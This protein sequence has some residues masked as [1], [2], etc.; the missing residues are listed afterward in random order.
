MAWQREWIKVPEHYGPEDRERL[1]YLYI[2]HIIE[3][4]QND[5]DR[6]NQAFKAYK[7]P[8]KGKYSKDYAESLDFKNAGKSSGKIDL[9][10]TGD[11][12]AELTLLR[13]QRGKVLIGYEKGS[14]A[15][16]KVE[17][18]RLGN[19]KNRPPRDFLGFKTSS[20]LGES[21]RERKRIVRFYE[22]EWKPESKVDLDTLRE[23]YSS[24][25]TSKGT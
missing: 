19:G 18:N 1:A 13:S 24:T 9:T 25:K 8:K 3:R 11:M 17:G 2:E 6:N 5:R 12:L 4:T 20:D 14:E 21:D 16:G 7:G 22:N 23:L 10:L 15:E